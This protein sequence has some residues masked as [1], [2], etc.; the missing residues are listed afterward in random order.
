MAS[1]LHLR[2]ETM[3]EVWEAYSLN[4]QN[5]TELTMHSFEAYKNE[6][7]KVSSVTPASEG[8]IS[9]TKGAA[10]VSANKHKRDAALA[11][12]V[13]PLST[14]KR[15]QGNQHAA[16]NKNDS[17]VDQVAIQGG[18]GSPNVAATKKPTIAL[19]K[20]EERTK[21]GEVVVSYPSGKTSISKSSSP[22]D[23]RPRCVVSAQAEDESKGVGKYNITKPYRHMFTTLEDRAVALEKHLMDRKAAIIEQHGLS[24]TQQLSEDNH[25]NND[26]SEDAKGVFAPLEEVNVPRQENI[27]C[28]GRVCNEVRHLSWNLT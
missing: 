16:D 12:M 21:V 18:A 4:K 3:A 23:G 10:M 24:N 15:H 17:S 28:I 1:T 8:I 6:L 22:T 5:L 7:V 13:T 20:Y 9:S 27:T 14:A 26:G 2:P 25:N 19:P 11:A